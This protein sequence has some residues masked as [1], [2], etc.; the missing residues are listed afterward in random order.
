MVTTDVHDLTGLSVVEEWDVVL[1]GD[2]FYDREM[3]SHFTPWL[4][5]CASAGLLVLIGDPDRAY[6]PLEKLE[7][8]ASYDVATSL[9]LEKSA[10][11]AS[12]VWQVSG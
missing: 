8:M 5:A 1:A 12:T 6:L 9:D 4:R 2:V 7:R 11:L 10:V 3:A